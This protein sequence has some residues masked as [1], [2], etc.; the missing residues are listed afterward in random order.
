MVS[1]LGRAAK[2][3][4]VV[5]PGTLLRLNCCVIGVLPLM[6][7]VRTARHS[8]GGPPS[9]GDCDDVAIPTS[10]RGARRDVLLAA[11][12]AA[13]RVFRGVRMSRR[14]GPKTLRTSIRTA[15][16]HKVVAVS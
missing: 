16:Y 14:L 10:A 13:L 4:V 7:T 12:W 8:C 6:P 3:R 5:Y 2:T 9:G 15:P 1:V 11:A